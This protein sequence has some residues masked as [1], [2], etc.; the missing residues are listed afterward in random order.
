MALAAAPKKLTNCFNCLPK[1]TAIPHT[2]NKSLLI[3]CLPCRPPTETH[4]G[5]NA[6]TL[7]LAPPVTL[8]IYN[9]SRY[10]LLFIGSF[11]SN[12]LIVRVEAEFLVEE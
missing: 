2:V 6:V 10:I 7:A 3:V 9:S 11:S 1:E 5:P 4:R 8:T 12:R